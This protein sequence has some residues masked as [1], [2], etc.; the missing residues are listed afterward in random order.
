MPIFKYLN[1][2]INFH[3]PPQSQV[4][5]F[6]EENVEVIQRYILLDIPFYIYSLAPESIYFC[7]GVIINFMRSLKHIDWKNYIYKKNERKLFTIILNYY[8]LAT[9]EYINPK[10]VITFIDNSELFHWLSKNCNNIEFFAIQNGNRPNWE[11]ESFSRDSFHLKHYFCFGNYDV[12]R[13][14]KYNLKVDN[15][16][17]IGSLN[18]SIILN[19]V[20]KGNLIN[21][22][23]YDIC[24]V[25][26]ATLDTKAN[27]ITMDYYLSYE[28]IIK[29]LAKFI[30]E[31][32]VTLAVALRLDKR[33]SPRLSK[34]EKD[35]FDFIFSKNA[36]LVERN[37]LSSYYTALKSDVL[38]GS[39]TTIL[40]ECFGLGK[41]IM[42]C[43]V[44]DRKIFH[45][46]NSIILFSKPNYNSFKNRLNELLNESYNKYLERTSNYRAYVMNY[47]KDCLPH[48]F[49]RKKIEQFL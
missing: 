4:V 43:D 38:I 30:E 45:D 22:N 40:A 8:R 23:K 21:N 9:L 17:P 15:F 13:F 33:L 31:F 5:L 35:H 27:E 26:S 24:F 34:L 42:Y 39:G 41:K 11:L 18:G 49:I 3:A 19:E 47:N 20:E 14:K 2:K 28:L 29:Y 10:I 6:E 25:S 46:H 12:D 48:L 1:K 36:E 44:S 32:N 7:L 16:Y 37:K